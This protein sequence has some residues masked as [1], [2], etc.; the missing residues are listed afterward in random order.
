MGSWLIVLPVS[1]SDLLERYIDNLEMDRQIDGF[2]NA[3]RDIK[4]LSVVGRLI[5]I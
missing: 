4:T 2:T 5:E 3:L 1:Y